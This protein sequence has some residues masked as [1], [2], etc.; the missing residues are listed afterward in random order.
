MYQ[1]WRF[2]KEI[3]DIQAKHKQ[4]LS[5]INSGRSTLDSEFEEFI[6][7]VIGPI[8]KQARKEMIAE[9]RLMPPWE[10]MSSI[11]GLRAGSISAKILALIDDISIATNVSKLW[12]YAGYGVVN[13]R[14][15]R[16]KKGEQL[17]FNVALKTAFWEAAEQFI[18][19]K[20][21]FY[22]PLYLEEKVRLRKLHPEKVGK[23]YTDGHIHNMAERKITKIFLYHLWYV[24]RSLEGLPTSNPWIIDHGGHTDLIAPP[25]W[26][27]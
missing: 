22:Y 26:E 2:W 4:R 5:A 14:A 7:T 3:N 10:W 9:A 25:N 17:H 18:R 12:R 24:W 23:D 1:T 13:G 20:N 11:K 15:E 8:E 27:E 16:K 6:L 21:P 19:Q